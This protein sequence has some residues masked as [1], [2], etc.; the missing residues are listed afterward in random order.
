MVYAYLNSGPVI[1]TTIAKIFL[2]RKI[3]PEWG[4]SQTLTIL[5]QIS[6]FSSFRCKENEFECSDSTCISLSWKCDRH[7]DCTDGSDEIDCGMY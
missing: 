3:A 4:K 5:I 7:I 1:T 6:K 2:M